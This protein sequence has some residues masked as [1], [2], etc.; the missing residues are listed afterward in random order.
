MLDTIF[1]GQEEVNICFDW[2]DRLYYGS[3]FKMTM[4]AIYAYTAKLLF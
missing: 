1:R 4:A 3:H 2:V